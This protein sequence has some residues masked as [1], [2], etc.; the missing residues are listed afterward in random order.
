MT[1]WIKNHARN[2]SHYHTDPECFDLS[3]AESTREVEK[4]IV[5]QMGLE[6][7]KRCA[8]DVDQSACNQ[9]HLAALKDAAR[10]HRPNSKFDT[11][12]IKTQQI[13]PTHGDVI[14]YGECDALRREFAGEH[15]AKAYARENKIA[16]ATLT[17]HLKGECD[18]VNG[19]PALTHSSAFGWVRYDPLADPETLREEYREHSMQEIAEKYDVHHST[20]SRRLDA[21][22][23][24]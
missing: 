20:V 14:T 24:K 4:G 8:G 13:D 9:S 7:C 21:H 23:L 1:V 12:P 5:E 6:Q 17:K 2:R 16:R 18:C 11:N 19:E 3:R 22:N 15:G 10:E